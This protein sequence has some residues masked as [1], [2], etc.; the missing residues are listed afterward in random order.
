MTTVT[1]GTFRSSHWDEQRPTEELPIARASVRN[2]FTGVITAS[3]SCGYT[4]VYRDDKS[5]EFSGY[6][7]FTG[8][9]EGRS[10]S[11]VVSERG[12]FDVRGAVRSSFAVV[13][14]S[15]TGELTGL[16]GQ[17]G[18]TAEP[19]AQAVSYDFTPVWG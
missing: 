9:V 13:A 6:Q 2:D 4:L 10:G 7:H 16:A 19:G 15:G 1:H 12:T 8:T 18:Y 14:G 5:G 3:G 17:G 11:F